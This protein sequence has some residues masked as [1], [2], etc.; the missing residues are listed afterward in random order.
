MAQTLPQVATALAAP[1]WPWRRTLG[2]ALES[3]ALNGV[4]SDHMLVQQQAGALRFMVEALG[5]ARGLGQRQARAFAINAR[6]HL[7][8]GDAITFFDVNI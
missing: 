4:C 3:C 5:D 1:T 8:S 7:A 6:Q 2:V